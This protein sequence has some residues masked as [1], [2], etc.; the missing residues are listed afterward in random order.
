MTTFV[1]IDVS[2]ARLDVAVRPTGAHC[3]FL[4]NEEDLAKLVEMLRPVGEDALVVLEPTGGYEMAVVSALLEAKLAVAIVNAR[5]V[6]DYAKATGKLAKT[7]R[8]DARVLAEFGEAV[9]PSPR[10]IPD[11]QTRELEALV[12]R[13]RQLVDMCT[14]EKNRKAL[15][16]KVVRLQ[17]DKTIEF[18]KQQIEELDKQLRKH[19]Q[20]SPMWR[21]KE[22][23]LKSVPGVG[24]VTARTLIALLPELGTLNRKEVAALVGVAPFNNDSGSRKGRRQIWGGR[25]PVRSVLYMAT[26]TAVHHNAVLR[27]VYER[28]IQ[29]GKQHKV[30]LVACMR[31][32]LVCVNAMVRHGSSWNVTAA[33]TR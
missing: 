24:D 6:R 33:A 25:S 29:R 28:L 11:E 9:R 27:T 3:S 20:S 7:D 5:Q 13:R 17:L 1:G 31:K 32:L 12:T 21:E 4:N 19:I 16:P 30:A 22:N 15:A 14:M 26:L 23:L 18:I 8:I 2:K 10:P